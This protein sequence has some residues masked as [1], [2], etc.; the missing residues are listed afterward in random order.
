MTFAKKDVKKDIY[1]EKQIDD[2]NKKKL[3]KTP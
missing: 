1:D 3:F 2:E